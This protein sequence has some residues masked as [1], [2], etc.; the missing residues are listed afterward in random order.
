M[1]IKKLEDELSGFIYELETEN[2]LVRVGLKEKSNQGE[3]FKKYRS[4]FS[5]EILTQLKNLLKK[6]NTPK[7]IDIIERIYFT[8][9]ASFIG[10]KLAKLQD[11]ITTHFAQSKVTVDGETISYYQIGPRMAKERIFE[12]REILEKNMY[13]GTMRLGAYAAI[14]KDKSKV[15]KLYE[16]TGRLKE[17]EKRIQE[18]MKDKSQAFRLGILE[19]NKK[20]VLERHRHRYEVNPK[21]VDLLEKRGMVFSGYYMRGDKTRLMEY[22]ELSKNE[23]FIG[24]QSHPE[25]KSRLGNPSPLF[26]GFV[27]NCNK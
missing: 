5:G 17:D 18:L 4:L 8:I 3:I 1:D 15:L 19:K 16:E 24:T 25:F 11:E 12:K 22:I 6:K 9:A 7:A 10:D 20:T 13:G 23:F 14:L 26:Y 21:Y 2:R 27:K